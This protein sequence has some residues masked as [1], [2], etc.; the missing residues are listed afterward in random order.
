M[1]EQQLQDLAGVRQDL[2]GVRRELAAVR[3]ELDTVYASASWTVTAPL[4]WLP[5]AVRRLF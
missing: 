5:R 1:L 4:R 3:R 2:D